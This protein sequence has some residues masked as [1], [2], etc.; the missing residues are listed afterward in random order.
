MKEAG[1]FRISVFLASLLLLVCR[2][3]ETAQAFTGLYC[4]AVRTSIQCGGVVSPYRFGGGKRSPHCEPR[5]RNTFCLESQQNTDIDT[6]PD[7][8]TDLGSH[9]NATRKDAHKDHSDHATL[10]IRSE[11]KLDAHSSVHER[12]HKSS[13]ED[14]NTNLETTFDT[15]GGDDDDSNV[16][17][18]FWSDRQ[19]TT[20]SF[21]MELQELAFRDAQKA[22][23]TLES[24][25]ALYEDFCQTGGSGP[26]PFVKPD[27]ACYT[28]VIEG[29]LY[30]NNWYAAK[31]A[32]ALLDRME[33]M[34]DR[35]G[36]SSMEPNVFSYML[37]C[38]AWSEKHAGLTKDTAENAEAV[39]RNMQKRGVEDDARIYTSVLTGWCRRAS[40]VAGAM[41]RAEQI[42]SEMEELSMTN[43]SLR[44][45]VVT[46]TTMISGFA[47]TKQRNSAIQAS[48]T[49]ARMKRHGVK[50]DIVSYTSVLNAFSR[51]RSR[52]ERELS[53][54]WAT[55]LMDKLEE[56]YIE[57]DH[58]VKPSRAFYTA[59]IL[60]I[61]NSLATDAMERAEQV[62]ERMYRLHKQGKIEGVKPSTATYNA[63]INA[64]GR[65]KHRRELDSARKAEKTLHEMEERTKANEPNV[66]PDERTWGAVIHAWAESKSPGAGREAERV[67]DEMERRFLNGEIDYCPNVVCYTLV[68]RSWNQANTPDGLERSEQLLLRMERH[69]RESF[70]D[71]SKPAFVQPNAI[72]YISLID[73]YTR[74]DPTKSVMRAQ[75]LVDR[76]VRN[77]AAGFGVTPSRKIFNAL[78]TAI[79]KSNDPNKGNKAE[80][81]L[82]WMEGQRRVGNGFACPNE[83]TFCGVLNAWASTQLQG[84]AERAQ[85]LLDHMEAKTTTDRGF[86]LTTIS[87]NICIK[88]WA[89]SKRPDAIRKVVTLIQRMEQQHEGVKPDRTT[90]CSAINCCAYYT[91]PEEGKDDAF[92][93]AMTIFNRIRES[94]NDGPNDVAYGTLLKAISRLLDDTDNRTTLVLDLFDRCIR[95][96]QMNI[97][98]LGQVR[99][100][101]P[102]RV[103][104]TV[105]LDPIG[106]RAPMSDTAMMRHIPRDWCQNATLY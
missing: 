38:Q 17:F 15:N 42:L 21:N 25:E 78:I 19:R 46:Y 43:E 14:D 82:E 105:V 9:T 18:D 59:A 79:S 48:E 77:Y 31:N 1:R 63:F 12:H 33:D 16:Q 57:G 22:Q 72:T 103:F 54:K 70:E 44:P 41:Q 53:A 84:G 101:L 96:G 26:S 62:L 55:E 28:T 67:L 87:Y 76:L 29:W 83:I 56:D 102:P 95:A 88:A 68:M 91:G 97:F 37:V 69:S 24:M 85:Q 6:D 64:L 90:Y 92:Q 40:R 49:I 3:P 8:D 86:E 50:P 100:V 10:M 2:A 23:E 106:L 13:D 98:V 75:Q 35:T 11:A 66:S 51:A 80:Q 52:R 73:A 94:D 58:L 81:V 34:Y 30:C 89:R 36:D 27:A 5:N 45:N 4:S 74:K 71:P 32:Q 7:R 60:A 47:Y 99:Q 65:I 93:I 39:L 20:Q 61:G 104:Q